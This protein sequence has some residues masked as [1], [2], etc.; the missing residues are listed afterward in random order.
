MA[1]LWAWHRYG[2][3]AHGH[4]RGAG[5]GAVWRPKVRQAEISLPL[6]P[7]LPVYS[8]LVALYKEAE[9]VPDLLVGLGLLAWPR[10]KLEIKLVCEQDDAETIAAINVHPLRSFVEVILVPPSLP[11]TKPK[12]LAYALRLSRG[13]LIVLYDAEDRPHPMQLAEAW[14]R[15]QTAGRDLACLQAPLEIANRQENIIANM[16]GFEYAALFRGLLPWLADNRITLPLGGTSNHFC[17]DVLEEIGGWDPYNVTEDA[18]VG[19]RLARH[20]YRCETL[21]CPT[22]EQ[23]PADFASWHRQRVR[24]FKGWTR[25]E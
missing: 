5:R 17:R 6:S 16:F 18:D 25:L 12:A 1:G 15:F 8:V 22:R 20:G 4:R 24:W 19:L 21:S 11:R 23:A 10:S 7:D 13:E 9:V 14:Q 2:H 3:P